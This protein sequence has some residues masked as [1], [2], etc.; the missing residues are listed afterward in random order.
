MAKTFTIQDH[1][2]FLK[3][4]AKKYKGLCPRKG[5]IW[6]VSTP[7]VAFKKIYVHNSASDYLA[8][9]LAS[10]PLAEDI[11][12]IGEKKTLQS[13]LKKKIDGLHTLYGNTDGIAN[14]IIP[15][16]ALVYFDD[17][18]SLGSADFGKLRSNVAHLH[19]IARKRDQ[20][21]VLLGFSKHDPSFRYETPEYKGNKNGVSVLK[22]T[23]GFET[24]YHSRSCDSGIHFFLDLQYA[25]NY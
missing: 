1:V 19:S 18:L 15:S 23:N 17:T 21:P 14:L 5:N 20:K 10:L 13:S 16:G 7:I 25:L 24:G 11:S 6:T 22:P 4:H 8:K 12:D 3:T 2:D 9:V